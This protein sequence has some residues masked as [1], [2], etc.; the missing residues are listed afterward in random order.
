MVA[1]RLPQ[2]LCLSAR[3]NNFESRSGSAQC[4]PPP[5]HTPFAIR[6]HFAMASSL[7]QQLAQNASLNT[8]LLVDRS[9][10]QPTQSYLFTSREADQHDLDSI[11]ALGANGFQ[12]L[13]SIEPLFSQYEDILFSDAAKG[14]D[15]TLQNAEAN[16]QLDTTVAMFLQI[17][18]PYLLET[19]SAKVLEWLVRRFRYVLCHMSVLSNVLR[20][21]CKLGSMSSTSERYLQYFC[22]IKNLSNF[23]RCFPS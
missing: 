2:N 20:I 21:S 7:A 15:R 18:G 3:S 14:T 1:R 10:R 19:P 17:L 6:E 16:S 22:R 13:K 8:A 23:P 4:S 5:P 11:Y 12:R 9:R